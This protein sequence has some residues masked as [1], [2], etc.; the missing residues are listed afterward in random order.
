MMQYLPAILTILGHLVI[1]GLA[2][3]SA[4]AGVVMVVSYGLGL[5]Q[6]LLGRIV[7]GER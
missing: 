7:R 1:L 5:L 4:V 6:R 3:F 2:A